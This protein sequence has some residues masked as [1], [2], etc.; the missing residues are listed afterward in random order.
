MKE[1]QNKLNT[2]KKVQDNNDVYTILFKL[3]NL[4]IYIFEEVSLQM[5][6]LYQQLIDRIS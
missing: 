2:P 3:Y 6:L 1:K 5:D 4:F